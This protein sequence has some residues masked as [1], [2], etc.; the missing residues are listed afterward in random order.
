MSVIADEIQAASFAKECIDQWPWTDEQLN[1]L[2][3]HL[4]KP[5]GEVELF[6]RCLAFALWQRG[7]SVA[8]RNGWSTSKDW[9]PVDLPTW[10]PET[11]YLIRPI[12]LLPSIDWNAVSPRLKWLTQDLSGV[13]VLFEKKPYANTFNGSW[14]TNCAG[15][16]THA[17]NFVSAKQGRGHWRDL[18]VERLAQ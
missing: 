4:D 17:D 9:Q 7:H 13:M 18:I 10:Q 2:N 3:M 12:P 6:H 1:A 11:S 16:L 5:F 15:H 8:F 14:T